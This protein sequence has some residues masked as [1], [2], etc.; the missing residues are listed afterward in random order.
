MRLQPEVANNGAGVARQKYLPVLD[1]FSLNTKETRGKLDSFPFSTQDK[2]TMK[3]E[4][5][6]LPGIYY[7][8][9]LYIE[10]IASIV[11]FLMIWGYPGAAWCYH[12]LLQESE[13]IPAEIF[14]PRAEMAMWQL[15]NCSLLLGLISLLVYRAIRDALPDNPVAQERIIGAVVSTLGL[16]DVS[17]SG[18]RFQL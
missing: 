9:F 14:Q 2:P 17:T 8:H 1:D 18:C 4:F 6:A 5:L 16:G 12:Q 3:K 7:V 10:P 13:E 11:A 15:G